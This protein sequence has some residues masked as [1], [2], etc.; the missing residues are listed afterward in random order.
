MR[1]H[2]RCLCWV[3]SVF[4]TLP[5]VVSAQKGT[6]TQPSDQVPTITVQE[7]GDTAIKLDWQLRPRPPI[8]F[9]PFDMIDPHTGKPVS[10]DDII[11]I[12]GVKITA[13][14]YYR[15][16]NE[17]ERWL[18]AH[19]YSLL[20]D[21]TIEFYS[22]QLEQEIADSEKRLREL[23]AQMPLSGE[24]LQSEE[25]YPAS[26]NGDGRWFD[27][28]W[29]GNSLYGIRF[30]GQGSYYA[31]P[32]TVAVSG[33]AKLHGHIV[34]FPAE[35]AS[36]SAY[37]Q[38]DTPDFQRI[39]YSYRFNVKVFGNTVWAPSGT[40]NGVYF[41]Q[42]RQPIAN[43]HWFADV[44]LAC[45]WFFVPVCVYGRVGVLGRLD[46]SARATLTPTDQIVWAGPEGYLTGYAEGWVGINLWLLNIAVGVRGAINFLTGGLGAEAANRLTLSANGGQRCV[47]LNFTTRLAA[48]LTALSGQV[49]LLAR[50]CIWWFGWHCHDFIFPLFS[51][52][53]IAWNYDI[54]RWSTSVRLGCF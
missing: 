40:G 54:A 28:G 39:G 23:E 27:T 16:L 46:M 32:T 20:K 30:A 4:I 1:Q 26:C 24:P 51:W 42:W 14:E 50:G 22:P 38:I 48:N 13:G 25:F 15:R 53:G 12:N 6:P 11:E 35:I 43:I 2:D 19:G 21:E 18:N 36:A 33:E 3:I 45:I 10:P 34:G 44:P 31:C 5:M 49:W 37:A 7:Q 41:Q 52:S 8:Q 47:D 29:F 17:M 9:T